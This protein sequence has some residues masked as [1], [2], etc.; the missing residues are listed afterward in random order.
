MISRESKYAK[1][2]RALIIYGLLTIRLLLLNNNERSAQ[3]LRDILSLYEDCSG[4][5]P[6]EEDHGA[7]EPVDGKVGL[8]LA[9]TH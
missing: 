8:D 4:H 5:L 1:T 7:D 6:R 9:G 3:C 2:L